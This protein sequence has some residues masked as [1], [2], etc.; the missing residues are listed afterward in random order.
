[1]KVELDTTASGSSYVDLGTQ[2]M[3]SVPYALYASVSGSTSNLTGG[4]S[5]SLD[6]ALI[7]VSAFSLAAG[8]YVV[9]DG[10]K[11]KLVSLT[12]LPGFATLT[13]DYAYT[14][15]FNYSNQYGIWITCEYAVSTPV[16]VVFKINNDNFPVTI[17]GTVSQYQV[18][19]TWDCTQCPPTQT[20]PNG[21]SVNLTEIQFPIWLNEGE[22]IQIG[23]KL[24][25]S[26]EVYK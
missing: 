23:D 13:A 25:L 12:K 18:N 17:N 14:R 7:M 9:P 10:Q 15:C 11:W 16:P 6:S 3:M 24:R 22:S 5:P 8:T 21:Y 19:G 4:S 26:V 2:Q 20:Q 1:M